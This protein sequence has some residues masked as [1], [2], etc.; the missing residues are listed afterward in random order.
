MNRKNV[1]NLAHHF[2]KFPKLQKFKLFIFK[3]EKFIRL[4]VKDQLADEEGVKDE[5]AVPQAPPLCRKGLEADTNFQHEVRAE[6]IVCDHVNWLGLVNHTRPV[7]LLIVAYP[8]SIHEDDRDGQEL[9]VVR[10]R[11]SSRV[12]VLVEVANVV[13]PVPPTMPFRTPPGSSI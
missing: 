7:E 5:P 11:K 2:Q 8:E 6:E 10:S 9:E 12:V 4:L 1:P 13:W 3:D